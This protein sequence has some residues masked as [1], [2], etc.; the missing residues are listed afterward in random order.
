MKQSIYIKLDQIS[1][2]W[3]LYAWGPEITKKNMLGIILGPYLKYIPKQGYPGLKNIINNPDYLKLELVSKLN[4]KDLR[5]N[6]YI[7]A[8]YHHDIELSIKDA[9]RFDFT[10]YMEIMGS[11]NKMTITHLI[12]TYIEKNNLPGEKLNFDYFKK[13]YYK[14]RSVENYPKKGS[15]V[16]SIGFG[17]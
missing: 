10:R 6:I 1:Q 4:D 2:E 9:M 12:E 11:L 14:S 3:V 5:C 15:F 13:Y 8:R 17:Y 7:A 16:A